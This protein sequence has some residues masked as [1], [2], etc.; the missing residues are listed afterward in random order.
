VSGDFFLTLE[1]LGFKDFRPTYFV[2]WGMSLLNNPSLRIA[3]DGLFGPD[4]QEE[5]VQQILCTDD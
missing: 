4:V 5:Y 3:I 1:F 2:F